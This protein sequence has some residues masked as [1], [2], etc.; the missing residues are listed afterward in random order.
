MVRALVVGE[1][2]GEI[3]RLVSIAEGLLDL[4]ATLALQI[5]SSSIDPELAWG[6][7][8]P[9]V[10]SVQGAEGCDEACR[11]EGPLDRDGQRSDGTEQPLAVDGE[12][13]R[14]VL[15]VAHRYDVAVIV[16]TSATERRW[17][18]RVLA[19][20]AADD[21]VRTSD[22]PLLLVR[23]DDDREPG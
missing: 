16:T 2:D 19:G 23:A 18:A 17:F 22:V 10:R 1:T 5:D 9:V 8:K 15:E 11:D 14:T 13:A 6:T 3:A 12:T 21:L 4:E 7:A 20:S